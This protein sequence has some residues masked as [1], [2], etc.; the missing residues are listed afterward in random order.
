MKTENFKNYGKC[1]VFERGGVKLM[2]TLDVGPRIIWFGTGEFNFMNEDLERNVQKGGEFFDEHY[3]KGATWY[4]YGGHRVWKSPEDLETYTPD[5]F[6]VEADVRGNGGTFTCRV[7]KW[8]DYALDVEM[9]ENG[10]VTVRN[11]VTNKSAER[12]LAVWGLTVARKGGTLVLPLNDPVDDLNPVYNLVRW[13][14]NDP[15]DARL[16]VGGKFLTLRQTDREDAI[17]IGT[18]AKKGEA[19]Y[20]V[21]DKAMKWTCVPEEG[22]QLRKLHQRPHP[23]GGVA[24][25]QSDAEV[26]R[27]PYHDGDV[28][29]APACGHPGDRRGGRGGE[30]KH[31][32]CPYK[33][34]YGGSAT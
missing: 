27:E 4:L 23:R 16:R 21:G 11:T 22:E 14:Y 30:I 7:A 9:D 28:A 1:A 32:S 34:C 3:G 31:A 2:V 33:P 29:G 25:P 8:L 26:G 18:F 17:K 6:P 24:L 20:A 13:P 12:T 15:A 10:G 19:Y 5:N